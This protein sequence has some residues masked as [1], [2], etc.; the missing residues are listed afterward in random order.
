MIPYNTSGLESIE[1]GQG[2]AEIQRSVMNH[3]QATTWSK[4][5]MDSAEQLRKDTS[6]RMGGWITERGIER[7][8]GDSLCSV[9]GDHSAI[10]TR[11]PEAA[12]GT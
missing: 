6:A 1:Q 3:P 10:D 7:L 11:G 5:T 2:C 8:L 4:D 12:F 9:C